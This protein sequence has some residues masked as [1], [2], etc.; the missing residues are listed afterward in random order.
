MTEGMTDLFLC[1][2]LGLRVSVLL[3]APTLM[4]CIGS[5]SWRCL[6]V[7]G[8]PVSLRSQ[9]PTCD[10]PACLFQAPVIHSFIKYSQMPNWARACTKLLGSIILQPIV[11]TFLWGHL[12]QFMSIFLF[13]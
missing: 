1:T 12:L 10:H 6:L 8:Q 7:K 13:L 2:V 4:F 11:W 9:T 3:G 5:A